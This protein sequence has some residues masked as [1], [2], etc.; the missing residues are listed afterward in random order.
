MLKNYTEN[1]DVW[2]SEIMRYHECDR[3]QAKKIVLV[4]LFG[5]EPNF[6]HLK[7]MPKNKYRPHPWVRKLADELKTVRKTVV[8]ALWDQYKDLIDQKR[9]EKSDEE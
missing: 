6:K 4:V 2:L 7:E 5:G 9:E 1:R 8:D 3:D